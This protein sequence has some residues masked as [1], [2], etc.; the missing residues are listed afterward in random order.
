MILLSR[1]ILSSS[2][3]HFVLFQLRNYEEIE[4]SL[5]VNPKIRRPQRDRVSDAS[6]SL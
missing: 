3:H 4:G 2:D 5:V 6:G 1:G